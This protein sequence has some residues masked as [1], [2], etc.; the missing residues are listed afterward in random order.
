MLRALGDYFGLLL[1]PYRL[2]MEREVFASPALATPQSPAFYFGL[3]VAG[4]LLLSAFAAGA[5]LP[6]RGRRL[7]CVGA[8]WFLVAFLPISNLFMLNASVAEHWL[9][10][11]S[12]GFLLFAAGVALDVP[13]GRLPV[14]GIRL[15]AA[16]AVAV[17]LTAGALGLRTW[18]RAHDWADRLTFYQQTIRDGG[19]VPRARQGLA[20]A[21]HEAGNEEAAATVLKHLTAEL[22]QM[23]TARVNLATT[24]IRLGQT[25]FYI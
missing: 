16:A 9:Y 24:S 5:L 15:L 17:G 11:P 22:P 6:G 13:W 14:P 21:Y 8:G 18:L 25:D 1:F 23:L 2:H 7:R 19:D 12:I 20:I 4:V 3:A 10:L